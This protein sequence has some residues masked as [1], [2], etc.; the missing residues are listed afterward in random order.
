[1]NPLRSILQRFTC[2]GKKRSSR[3]N[4]LPI[5]ARGILIFDHT[6]DVIAAE[7]CLKNAGLDIRVMGPPPDVRS[8]CDLVIE[9]PLIL[10]LE[11]QRLLKA[12]KISPVQV[13]PVQDALLEPVSL[14]HIRH[15][16]DYLMVRTAN[17]KLTVHKPD[18]R[19][20]NVSGGGCP[21]IPWLAEQLVGQTLDSAPSPRSLGKTLC[22]YALQIA[23]EEMRRQCPG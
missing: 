18:R 10:E 1:M 5:S 19:I 23:Y 7:S 6:G 3:S 2:D 9:F 15:M 22:G 16:G 13:V 8:G 17:M 11:I 20:V 4:H 12:S 21:D 14:F